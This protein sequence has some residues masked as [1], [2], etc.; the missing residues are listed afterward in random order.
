VVGYGSGGLAL[1]DAAAHTKVADIHLPAHPEGFQI[2][3]TSGRAYVNIPDARQIAVVDLDAR[4]VVA[5]W[6]VRNADGNFPMALEPAQL[7]LAIAFRSPPVLMLLNPATGEERQR[8]PVCGD[9]DDVFFDTQRGRAYVSCG[10]GEVDVLEREA[11]G[12]RRLDSVRT[13]SGARTS[14]F[15]PQVDR[16]FVA[17]RAGLLGSDATVRVYRPS[18]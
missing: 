12:W 4:R 7:L 11:A 3:P 5:T 6:P 8:L 16:L 1:I 9:P 14:L 15:V 17:E 2:D 13:A 18:P 10:A